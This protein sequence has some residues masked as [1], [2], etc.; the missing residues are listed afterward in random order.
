MKLFT[1][2]PAGYLG[3][4]LAARLAE[5]GHTV[6]GPQKDATPAEV[7]ALCVSADAAVL[8]LVH[9]REAEVTSL[10]AHIGSYDFAAAGRAGFTV[11][12]V[13]TVMT[14]NQSNKSSKKSSKE[15]NWKLRK[16]SPRFKGVRL[17]ETAVLSA[18]REGA[19][20]VT[21]LVVAAGVLYG[22]G[23]DD[24]HHLFKAAWMHAG[25]ASF[26][27]LPLIG[28]GKNVIPT[29]HVYDLV[30]VL[31]M[32]LEAAAAQALEQSYFVAVDGG[33]T[34]QKALV[35]AIA[36]GVGDGKI[37][38]V[39]RMDEKVLL[40][41][42]NAAAGEHADETNAAAA[43]SSATASAAPAN[44]AAVP[45]PAATAAAL[46]SAIS[47][48]NALTNGNPE[49][50]LADL[51]IEAEWLA[52]QPMEWVCE[53]GP[54]SSPEVFEQLRQ[55]F[56]KARNLRP[57]RVWVTGAPGSGKSF[58]SSALSSKLHVP[59]IRLDALIA[60]A[61]QAKDE[62]AERVAQALVESANAKNAAAAGGAGK[63]KKKAAAKDKAAAMLALQ[64]SGSQAA[65][66]GAKGKHPPRAGSSA[67]I[68]S[69]KGG[70]STGGPVDLSV[71]DLDA[72]RLPAY[73]LCK[74]VK[75]AVR[76]PLCRNKGFILDGFPRTA[77]ESRWFFSPDVEEDPET[78]APLQQIEDRR[79]I[80]LANAALAEDEGEGEDASALEPAEPQPR[81][82]STMV[83]SVVLL[84]CSEPLAATRL[85]HLAAA[86]VRPGHNDEEGFARRW[87]RFHAIQEANGTA[88]T[89]GSAGDALAAQPQHIHNPLHFVADA[90]EVLELPEDVAAD[91]ASRGLDIVLQY[92]SKKSGRPANYHPTPEETEAAQRTAD[93]ARDKAAQ[94]AKEDTKQKAAEESA[95]RARAQTNASLRRAAVLLE[96]QALVDASAAPLRSYLLANVIPALV[97]GLLDVARNQPEDPVDAL[98]EYLF[99]YSVDVPADQDNAQDRPKL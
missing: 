82:A 47:A 85:K 26:P 44:G 63:G 51:K 88:A 37:R 94:Q 3:R 87:A 96:D 70:L 9:G 91:S 30:S 59:H 14:W 57:V 52:G 69:G 13:S 45:S 1:L 29:I 65:S 62:F 39:E 25:D 74:L 48:A 33:H 95:A 84:S 77:E 12:G 83:D 99:K 66:A 93:E 64:N 71:F 55:E 40:A 81:D 16:C 58:Y 43:A 98:A 73:L 7:Q 53:Q 23:E 80:A 18:A 5:H 31:R 19:A 68:G 78:G 4:A 21:A 34:T 28:D 97:D 10:L 24:L 38:N 76:A 6:V 92:I 15:S 61:L 22:A 11:V 2:E 35:T 56:V 67:S 75:R 41:A 89:G 79:A 49:L 50:I 32:L 86:E 36:Q 90:V 46:S 20:P 54:A 27:G 60:Q 42:S 17:L 72:P 8:D